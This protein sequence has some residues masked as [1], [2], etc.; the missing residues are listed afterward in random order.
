[1]IWCRIGKTKA[2][3]LRCI[4][5]GRCKMRLP[6]KGMLQHSTELRN[7]KMLDEFKNKLM[8]ILLF[9]IMR[10][11]CNYIRVKFIGK[12]KENSQKGKW[13]VSPLTTTHTKK[14]EQ[15][16]KTVNASE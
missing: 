10:L 11:H 9:N 1:M 16:G 13:S 5:G 2:D 12:P 14:K 7:E 6:I 15:V 4:L 3:V 8:N